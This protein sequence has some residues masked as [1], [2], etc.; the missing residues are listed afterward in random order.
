VLLKTDIDFLK[1]FSWENMLVKSPHNEKGKKREKKGI[2]V[3]F[4]HPRN[5]S[6]KKKNG[7]QCL[8][9][10][11]ESHVAAFNSLRSCLVL[12]P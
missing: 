5:N 4:P 7:G 10:W 6:L 8:S 9:Y 1:I 11:D 12:I 2:L 3:F